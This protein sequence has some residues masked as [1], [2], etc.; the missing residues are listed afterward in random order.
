[1]FTLPRLSET[2]NLSLASYAGRPVV[3]NFWASDCAPCRQEMPALRKLARRYLGASLAV[4]GV[5]EQDS[6]AD[7]KHYAAAHSLNFP[8]V[9]DAEYDVAGRFR[10]IGTPE[11][12]VLDSQHRLVARLTGPITLARNR[13]RLD[14]ALRT[15]A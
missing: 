15:V 5:V 1:M 9:F 10:V 12:F 3:L 14:A 13:E 2:G 8:N 7:A 4:L 11:T 6:R